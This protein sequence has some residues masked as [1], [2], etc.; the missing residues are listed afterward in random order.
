MFHPDFKFVLY[1]SFSQFS[2]TCCLEL[3]EKIDKFCKKNKFKNFEL[4]VNKDRSKWGN[5]F[6]ITQLQQ[7][8]TVHSELPESFAN[9]L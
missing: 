6:I 2:N 3:L 4:V 5:Q 1:V 9:M 8:Q 7:Y